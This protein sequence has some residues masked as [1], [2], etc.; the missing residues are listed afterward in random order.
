MTKPPRH[1]KGGR[2][3]FKALPKGPG[4]RALCRQCGQ[5][6]PEGRRSFCSQPCVDL[7]CIRTGSR[8]RQAVK[9]RDKGI[10]AVCRFDCKLK[11]EQ[12]QRYRGIHHIPAHRTKLWDVDHII[13]VA[14][15][16]GDAGL[17]N[18]RTLCIPCHR[19]VTAELMQRLREARRDE[20]GT[21]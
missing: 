1:L 21:D 19:S 15:G 5:E 14:E 8:M 9:K 18:L 2:C 16:G 17:E 3:N 6:V 13:P 10:C 12:A 11:G 7:W 20:T 4:G